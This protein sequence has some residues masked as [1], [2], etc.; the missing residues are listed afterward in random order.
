MYIKTWD[1]LPFSSLYAGKTRYKECVV[2]SV[3][4]VRG[5]GQLSGVRIPSSSAFCVVICSA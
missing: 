5:R 3:E 2:P 4:R 1:F